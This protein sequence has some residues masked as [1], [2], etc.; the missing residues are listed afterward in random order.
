MINILADD[1]YQCNYLTIHCR[2]KSYREYQLIISLIT[3]KITGF[4]LVINLVI[5]DRTK[6]QCK[7]RCLIIVDTNFFLN[8]LTY[9]I[10][11][12]TQSFREILDEFVEVLSLI[13]A[14]SIDN[15]IHC[16]KKVFDELTRT[17][18]SKIP[19]LRGLDQATQTMII[20]LLKKILSVQEVSEEIITE[21]K[22]F[23]DE[24]M[25]DETKVGED[26]LSLFGLA[27]EKFNVN[28]GS[29]SIIVTDDSDFYDV[30]N[31]L[32]QKN[33]LTVVGKSY[34]NLEIVPILSL[35]FLTPIYTCCQFNGLKKYFT[36]VFEHSLTIKDEDKK[37]RKLRG[38][39]HWWLNDF[40]EAIIKKQ[41]NKVVGIC[42]S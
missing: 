14:C 19:R 32:K 36:I 5:C 16:S 1:K 2:I 38:I 35:T 22:A 4:N 31:E 3:L 20:K 25:H 39:A 27:L 17:I 12:K 9:I 40:E 6:N 29:F 41:E 15:K 7:N 10:K 21:L 26:D 33:P 37:E 28:N 13:S 18:F 30:V 23:S 11:F 42:E 34:T 24:I 8:I